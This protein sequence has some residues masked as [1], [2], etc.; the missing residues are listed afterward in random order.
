M[1]KNN[2]EI[3]AR[4]ESMDDKYK[5]NDDSIDYKG[6]S[7]ELKNDIKK[8]RKEI[9]LSPNDDNNLN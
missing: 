6:F 2:M 3:R 9:L 7:F 1:T 5:E 4:L 8:D